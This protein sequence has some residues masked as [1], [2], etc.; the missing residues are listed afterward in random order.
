MRQ[1]AA[2][3]QLGISLPTFACARPSSV[4]RSTGRVSGVDL[5]RR[6]SAGQAKDPPDCS[7][8]ASEVACIGALKD[9]ADRFLREQ[10]EQFR[11][12]ESYS[13][14]LEE[15]QARALEATVAVNKL[16]FE[17]SALRARV[18][19]DEAQI[20]VLSEKM[21][22][23]HQDHY[24]LTKALAELSGKLETV[25]QYRTALKNVFESSFCSIEGKVAQMDQLQK[26]QME[27]KCRLTQTIDELEKNLESALENKAAAEARQSDTKGALESS[28]AN[29][30]ELQE[31]LQ[32]MMAD[33]QALE[34]QLKAE[35]EKLTESQKIVEQ[36]ADE[37]QQAHTKHG[38]DEMSIGAQSTQI[39][40]LQLNLQQA[41]ERQIAL[42][43][44][45]V[46]LTLQTKLQTDNL[47]K[48]RQKLASTY[49]KLLETAQEKKAAEE[50]ALT[51]EKHS[52]E[53]QAKS[54][55]LAK[56][57]AAAQ[58]ATEALQIDLARNIALKD[59][60]GARAQD[61]QRHMQKLGE[62]TA[63]ELQKIQADSKTEREAL[64][65]KM[66]L[67]INKLQNDKASLA[68]D[69]QAE[70]QKLQKLQA[71]T[72]ADREKLLQQT[73][74]D[75]ARL[76]ED[77]QN[78]TNAR[79]DETTKQRQQILTLEM[80]LEAQLKELESTKEADQA[81]TTEQ[82]TACQ[83]D[84]SKSQAKLS[85]ARDEADRL[86]ADMHEAAAANEMLREK[87]AKQTEE[88]AG[89]QVE[90]AEK[91]QLLA[92]I[93]AAAGRL[94]VRISPPK[95]AIPEDDRDASDP[96]NTATTPAEPAKPPSKKKKTPPRFPS[97]LK[98][99]VQQ[100]PSY[101]EETEDGEEYAREI[102][103]PP[104]NRRVRAN[105]RANMAGRPTSRKRR[106]PAP[107]PSG[108]RAK[109]IFTA[110]STLT[111]SDTET[112]EVAKRASNRHRTA[113]HGSKAFQPTGRAYAQ[114]SV[115]H[116]LF[117]RASL[118]DPYNQQSD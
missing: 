59:E 60:A 98:A 23:T 46:R 15:S 6:G 93:S 66:S 97:H 5:S 109:S 81:A 68:G 116:N 76:H 17:N 10:E 58:Q 21:A 30:K 86:R 53:L 106:L 22:K 9:T 39:S 77:L 20:C 101:A 103:S 2:Q 26:S 64:A 24:S 42:G 11:K 43:Q 118:F 82:L 41:E 33:K 79:V 100:L 67:E 99:K 96:D 29:V 44:E 90:F 12:S 18:K 87:C 37:I 83:G 85:S 54:S 50:Q 56:D 8:P 110:M 28:E 65:Q 89:L 38:A 4:P 94:P 105:Q 25:S 88:Y 49:N 107:A 104:Q 51:E 55:C 16:N 71:D 32:A 108:R 70:T 34:T 95:R 7:A 102:K 13:K 27:L 48:L 72:E 35:M 3:G 31:T 75:L 52:R 112:E 113:A 117:G 111:A 91:V 61:S 73:S 36:L 114:P 45:V 40:A 63:Q 115:A 92:Q 80:E 84:L 14:Q 19:D 57:L 69:L 1:T 62:R 47:E 78:Q 74:A